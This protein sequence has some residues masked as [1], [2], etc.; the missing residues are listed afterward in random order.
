MRIFLFLLPVSLYLTS[1]ENF[2]P[3]PQKRSSGV[4][5]PRSRVLV[6]LKRLI[7]LQG[8]DPGE[9]TYQVRHKLS[10]LTY[11]D[12]TIGKSNPRL[13]CFSLLL[14]SVIDS[15]SLRHPFS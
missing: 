9:D 7:S 3:F 14:C 10:F 5:S 4:R 1:M 12:A 6:S 15:E 13:H 8:F 2:S 11:V